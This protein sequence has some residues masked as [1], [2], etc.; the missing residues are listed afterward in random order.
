MVHVRSLASLLACAWLFA[1]PAH[2]LEPLN[3]N[4]YYRLTWNGISLGRIR[5]DSEESE[6]SYQMVVDTKSKGIVSLF[7]PFKTVAV[8]TGI[9][10]GGEYIP[11][12][13]RTQSERNNDCENCGTT[14]TYTESG[15]IETRER[16]PQDDPAWRPEVPL[17]EANTGSDPITAYFELRE[18]LRRNLDQGI[19]ATTVRTYDGKRLADITFTITGKGKADIRGETIP[20]LEATATRTP[21]NGYTPK[22]WKKFKEG[23]PIFHAL[24]ADDPTLRLVHFEFDLALG[25]LVMELS[26]EP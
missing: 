8:V 14:I 25:T 12:R 20:V 3:E 22:E 15:T 19:N 24:F 4:A 1:S 6:H 17:D 26:D 11:R 18:K 2:A 21:I 16:I 23:D 7:S 9:K 10:A 13:Y 5:I